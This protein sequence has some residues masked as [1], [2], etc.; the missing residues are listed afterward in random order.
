LIPAI[1][2]A[3][4]LLLP[5][6]LSA[7]DAS[8]PPEP[9]RVETPAVQ[10]SDT[11]SG[12]A[13]TVA[14]ETPE[15]VIQPMQ[16]TE[17]VESKI[18]EA[19]ANA[20]LSE[21]AKAKLI[22]R[23]RAVAS[24]LEETKAHGARAENYRKAIDSAPRETAT[25]RA[26]LDAA[27]PLPDP[28]VELPADANLAAIE[29]RLS[30]ERAE[31]AAQEARLAELDKVIEDLKQEPSAARERLD[32]LKRALAELDEKLNL[33]PP[34]GLSEAEL[35]AHQWQLE[36]RRDALRAE[37]LMLEQ[38]VLSAEARR[39]LAEAR[40]DLA[41]HA[42]ERIK[43]RRAYLENEA[44]R[45]RRI[46]AKRIQAETEEAARSTET[47]A[48]LVHDLAEQNRALSEDI[49]EITEQLDRLDERDRE[50]GDARKR[51]EEEFDSAR[52]RLEAAGLSQAI[53]QV[54]LDQRAELPDLRSLRRDATE[55][56]DTIADLALDQVMNRDRLRELRNLQQAVDE[57]LAEAGVAETERAAL[58]PA[59]QEQLQRQRELLGRLIDI[60]ESWQRAI[61]DLDFKANQ[62]IDLV[63]RYDDFLAER[64]LWVRSDVPVFEQHFGALPKAVQ[65]LLSPEHWWE[66]FGVLLSQTLTSPALWL[67]LIVVLL[68][69]S[70]EPRLRRRIRDHAEPLRRIST[71]RFGHTLAALGLTL[72]LAAPWPL[73]CALIG[74]QLGG[75]L[76]ATAFTKAIGQAFIA[77]AVP[78]YYLR[79]FKLLCMNGGV[80]DRHFRWS[81]GTL[82]LLSRY[83]QIA[84]L[85]LLPLG[86]VTAAVANSGSPG[87]SG[88][89]VQFAIALLCLGLALL[90]ARLMHPTAGVLTDVL[91]E[92]P[93]G[94]PNRTRFLWYTI[95]VGVPAAVAVV[96]LAGYVY[97]AGVLLGSLVGE[98]WLALIL[99]VVHQSI[100]RWLIVTRRSLA[101]KAALD[102][103]ASREAQREATEKGA[104][105]P[106]TV[107]TDVDLA[108]LDSQT[109]RLLNSSI[110]I[111][112]S[113]GLWLIWSD[114]LPALN[115]FDR[116][117]LWTYSSGAN[118]EATTVPVTL[119]DI[120]LILVIIIAAIIA[121]RNLPALMEILLLKH[122]HVSAG[123]RYTIITLMGYVITA[124]GAVMVFS[125]LGLSWGQ[126]QWLVAALG[127]GIG[128]G[129]QEI[130]ANFISGLIILF[131]RPVRV[132][133]I[134]T[135]GDTTGTVSKIEIRATTIRNWDK[136]ELLVPNKE[137]ITG[138]LLNWTLTD[139]INRVVIPVGV[140]YGSDTRKALSLL[141]EA[142]DENDHVLKD[143]APLTT[144]ESFGDNSLMLFLRCYLDSLEFRLA[145]TTALHQAISDKFAAAG[146]SIA[147]PQ[148]DIHLRSSEPLEVRFRR[149]EQAPDSGVAA[150]G[151]PEALR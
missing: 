108:S 135:I 3:A 118:G 6:A 75:S 148:R 115:V 40:R 56:A 8:E 42:L 11:A 48:P 24:N 101:L 112:A 70:R 85:A 145:T 138:R 38:R 147:F 139:Q 25:I 73:L 149:A 109:R 77:V 137:F 97:T 123:S 52:E 133:D 146:I 2:A 15:P 95:L 116:F 103:R 5:A 62:L 119:A 114:V 10:A 141:A 93:R 47:S 81:S 129:L 121:G 63:A 113:V 64:L 50:I 88:A 94:W 9:R 143:P 55:R 61:G 69:L 72:L 91:A 126:V 120:G 96:A 117:T 14:A 124:I 35:E 142:A 134:V 4:L 151:S 136:Q 71:D 111:A 79:A 31:A 18:A 68:L 27:Q 54:L 28:P 87:L 84:A 99:I 74:W 127:V 22:E 44:D 102:R 21:E 83:F 23:Y 66:V 110:F 53:G 34:E 90:T 33:P 140:A 67:G 82:R 86:F 128:F 19:E 57:T 12:P 104:Q 125:T 32:E 107:E 59:I 58:R 1:L 7:Q 130:V 43:Q 36:S 16:S 30:S 150:D 49:S 122:S 105:Q 26:Q 80:A 78:F 29:Q 92:H 51:V 106:M 89:F 98:L 132:G 41:E 13:E 60:Q 39:Q 65:W 45:L 37:V 20:A 100:V 144:F 131:E 76:Q 46:E 17:L